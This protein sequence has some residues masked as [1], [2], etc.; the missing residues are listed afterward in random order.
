M[1]EDAV[2]RVERLAS[3][4]IAQQLADVGLL[5]EASPATKQKGTTRRNDQF[6][7]CAHGIIS[8]EVKIKSHQITVVEVVFA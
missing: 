6:E 2:A 5:R 3:F 8:S 4:G 7:S 1:A